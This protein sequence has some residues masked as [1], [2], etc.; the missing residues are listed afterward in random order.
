MSA[1]D[2]TIPGELNAI[3]DRLDQGDMRMGRIELRMADATHRLE[4]NTRLTIE[5]TNLTRENA[6]TTQDIKDLIVAAKLGFK[7]IGGLGVAFKW[8]GIIAAAAGSI[9]SAYLL[10]RN[11]GPKP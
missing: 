7:V 3:H 9:Y 4:E 11:G 10:F 6:A 1:A 2:E 8:M 5:N